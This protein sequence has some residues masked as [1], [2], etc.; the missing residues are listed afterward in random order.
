VAGEEGGTKEQFE[1]FLDQNELG[2]ALD[3]LEGLSASNPVTPEF[4]E[5]L[6]LAAGEMGL[7]AAEAQFRA[8]L[9][10]AG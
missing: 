4:W 7:E 10:S 1:E 9:L 6:S 2:L 3:E 5:H 8:R